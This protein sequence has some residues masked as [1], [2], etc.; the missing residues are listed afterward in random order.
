[1]PAR[2]TAR[3][4]VG[5]RGAIGPARILTAK[6]IRSRLA[7]TRIAAAQFIGLGFINAPARIGATQLIAVRPFN[8]P[9]RIGAAERVRFGLLRSP[10]RIRATKLVAVAALAADT[11]LA[12]PG[13]AALTA[14]G[15]PA[16]GQFGLLAN[17]RRWPVC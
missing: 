4:R 8:T 11:F 9:A 14:F 1:M 6:F 10:A 2:K 7:P 5:I 15:I 17:L 13:Y 3:G 12:L 16:Q